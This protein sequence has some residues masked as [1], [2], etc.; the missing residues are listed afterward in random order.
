MY[1][2]GLLADAQDLFR[3]ERRIIILCPSNP[4]VSQSGDR[5]EARVRLLRSAN[6]RASEPAIFMLFF[7]IYR[8]SRSS[9]SFLAKRH[10]LQV[11]ICLYSQLLAD[12][13]LA[14]AIPAA[15]SVDSRFSISLSAFRRANEY[16]K[17]HVSHERYLCSW[18]RIFHCEGL[19]CDFTP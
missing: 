4:D 1:S 12:D 15:L 19:L 11:S 3:I 18:P 14:R 6:G 5:G 16:S 7:P 2:F 9:C 17:S 13:M 8:N 10:H